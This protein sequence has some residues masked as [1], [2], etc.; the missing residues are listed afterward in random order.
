MKQV[1]A[2]FGN[3]NDREMA[4]AVQIAASTDSLEEFNE[5]MQQ[6]MIE[7]ARAGYNESAN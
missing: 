2:A 3:L 5:Q 4:V 6:G 7:A 1:S